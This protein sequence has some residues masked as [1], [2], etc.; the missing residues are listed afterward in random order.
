[1]KEAKAVCRAGP[2][3]RGLKLGPLTRE[4]PKFGGK[5]FFFFYKYFW[6]ILKHLSL[7]FFFFIKKA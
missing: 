1:M 6:K 4:D 7:Y 3:L 5:F 2:K